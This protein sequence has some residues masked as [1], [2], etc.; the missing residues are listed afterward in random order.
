[1]HVTVVIIIICAIA[2]A[3]HATDYKI[4]VS[5]CVCRRSYGRNFYSIFMKFCTVVLGLKSKI[6]FVRWWKSLPLFCP[7]F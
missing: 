5:Q 7:D 3:Q 2:T 4:T 6:E 1:M